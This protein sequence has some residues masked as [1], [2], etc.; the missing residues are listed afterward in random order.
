[1][2]NDMSPIHAVLDHEATYHCVL[3]YGRLNDAARVGR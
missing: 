3:P 1:M 2:K